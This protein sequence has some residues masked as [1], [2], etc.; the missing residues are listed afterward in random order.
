MILAVPVPLGA[1]PVSAL[2]G[3]VITL[4]WCSTGRCARSVRSWAPT[5]ALLLGAWVDIL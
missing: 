2:E 4:I 3:L 5:Q 1:R